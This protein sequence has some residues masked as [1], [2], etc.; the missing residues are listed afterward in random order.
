M[1]VVKKR[2]VR[3]SEARSDKARPYAGK[4]RPHAHATDPG[5]GE[6]RA[7][8]S[9]AAEMAAPEMAAEAA[10]TEVASTEVAAA[11]AATG[12]AWWNCNDG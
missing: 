12:K 3:P 4:C 2:G 9:S 10:A 1:P 11:K 8:E 6:V 5:A 7:A